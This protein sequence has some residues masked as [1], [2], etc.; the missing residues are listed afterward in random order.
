MKQA[1]MLG[2]YAQ[3]LAEEKQLSISELSIC[4]GCE[5][6]HVESFFKGRAF[7]SFAQ[8]ASLAQ[9]LN[10]PVEKLLDGN[11]EQYEATVV[12]CM[13]KFD[14]PEH[15]EMILDIIDDYMDIVNAVEVNG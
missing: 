11:E 15:R 7:L 1:R 3:H 14:N 2:N 5:D 6:K 13:H 8:I 12:H 9:K 10:V 4:L